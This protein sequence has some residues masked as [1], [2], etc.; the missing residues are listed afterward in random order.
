MI[1]GVTYREPRVPLS[2]RRQVFELV[3]ESRDTTSVPSCTC[4]VPDSETGSV[5][6]YG[7]VDDSC[8]PRLPE[9]AGS[10]EI[11]PARIG[12]SWP[13]FV[14]AA[15]LASETHAIRTFFGAK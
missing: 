9:R 5:L 3:Q 7:E 11:L 13:R 1:K 6:E 2:R 12:N 10:E 4:P 15:V 8:E 14:V